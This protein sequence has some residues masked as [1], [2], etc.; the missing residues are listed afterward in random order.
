MDI[1]LLMEKAVDLLGRRSVEAFEV[2]CSST[3]TTRVEAKHQAVE[4]LNRHRETGLAIR[5]LTSDGMG[6][7]YGDEPDDALVDAAVTSARHQTRDD[8]HHV[9]CPSVP[10]PDG[11]TA[12]D[13]EAVTLDADACIDAALRLEAAARNAHSGVEHVRKAAFTRS[14]TEI[15][16]VNSCGV[17]CRFPVTSV[18]ASVMCTVRRGEDVQSGYDFDFSHF[19]SGFDVEAVGR[20]AVERAAALLG[21]RRVATRRMPVLFDSS[22]ASEIFDFISESFLGEN[23]LK[24]K[25]FLKDS[26]GM[27]RFSACLTIVD[28]PLDVHAADCC[29]FDG[30]GMPSMRTV[31]V[32]R[33]TVSAFLYDAYWAR[34]SGLSSTGNSV[35][36]SYRAWPTLASRHISVVPGTV[37]LR[38]VLSGIPAVLKVMDIMGM[39]TANPITGEMSVGINGILLEHGEP[40]HPVREA[41]IAG[42]I[43]DMLGRVIAVGDDARAFGHVLCPSILVDSVDVGA[44]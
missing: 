5:V 35:R 23:V 36:S 20:R 29:P 1:D 16:I 4:T 3:D 17:A 15:R 26:L 9:P 25:S 2:F 28:D 32:D 19:V 43:F 10:Y 6:F 18:S 40:V 11:V 12:F 27:D 22:S 24:G 13:P 8:C 42:N 41:A 39:H 34:R 44:Q 38:E 14:M 21:A 37:P 31:L 33:G 30:E 7:A